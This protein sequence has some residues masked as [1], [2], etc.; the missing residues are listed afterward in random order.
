[1]MLIRPPMTNFRCLSEVT[2]LFLYVAPSLSL[3]NSCPVIVSGGESAF[4]KESVSPVA[5]IQ[6][7]ANIPFH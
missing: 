5:S 4:G 2:V 7:K 1:M 3:Q 6:H